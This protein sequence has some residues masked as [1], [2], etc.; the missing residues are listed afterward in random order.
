M[1]VLDLAKTY[2][3]K[4]LGHLGKLND[5][6]NNYFY[7]NGKKFLLNTG[8]EYLKDGLRKLGVSNDT[9]DQV[10]N[11]LRKEW[12]HDIKRDY[13]HARRKLGRPRPNYNAGVNGNSIGTS[14]K[15]IAYDTKATTYP[16][17]NG[18]FGAS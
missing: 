7:G 12:K 15:T 11:P 13:R 3:T 1:G 17:M 4:A 5:F 10:V 6:D 16:T 9:V 8:S 18:G 2:G 14:F